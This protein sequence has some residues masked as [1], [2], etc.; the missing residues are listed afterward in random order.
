MLKALNKLFGGR[1]GVIETAPSVRVLPL[2]DVEDEEIPRYPPFAK[3]LPVA[4]L[5]KILATQAELIEK[6]RNS[7]GFTVDDFNRLVLPVIQRYAAFVHLLPASESH[8]HRG[9][10]GLFRHGL[11]VAFWAAQASE[12][13]IF[14]IEGTPRER[15]DNEP[16]WRLASCFSGLLHDVGKPLSD[17]SIT[18]KDGSI[19]WNPYSES[20]HDWAHRHEIDRY[21]IRWRDKRHKRHEQFSLLA[22]DRIIPAETREFLSKSGPSIMEAMLEAISGTSVNQ[23]VTGAT[24]NGQCGEVCIKEN[25]VYVATDKQYPVTMFITEK[26]SEAQALSLTM[27]PRRIPPRE[28]FL[29]LDGGVGITGAFANTKAETW[30]Q[31][32]PYVETIRSVF[33]KIA[34]GEVPQGYTLN[35]IPAGA[36]VPSCAHPGVKVDFSKGQYMMGHHLNVFI[37]VALNVSDQ[38]IEFKEALC[39]S[40]DVAAVTTWPLNVLEPGQKTEIYVAKKQKRGLAPTSK[41]PSL[42]GGAQ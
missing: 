7:L 22:V 33:R 29:K 12:S 32:Q 16:R 13:V 31:S 3:G 38:P 35:R 26:G 27:V 41:R 15:R 10:G 8:H 4:P 21:F 17:V 5:D 39:G 19:T 36:A 40:W 23:P 9:A 34:L 11:E 2:K 37:G 14:S 28:V 6:V 18:D 1:S 25:V 42:L 24:D 20:L 30:E